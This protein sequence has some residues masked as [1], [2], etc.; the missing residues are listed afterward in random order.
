MCILAISIMYSTSYERSS[1]IYMYYY[2]SRVA[3]IL[4]EYPLLILLRVVLVIR[5]LRA[6]S[7]RVCDMDMHTTVLASM[8]T[9]NL[10]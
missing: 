10:L 6:R 3:I 5:V 1:I 9:V 4:L 7:T 2:H 8:H